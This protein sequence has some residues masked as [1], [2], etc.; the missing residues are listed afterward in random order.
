MRAYRR[1]SALRTARSYLAGPLFTPR[2]SQCILYSHLGLAR[3]ARAAAMASHTAC[4][5][6]R[7]AYEYM[8]AVGWSDGLPLVPPTRA[9]V[10]HML[11]GTARNP[12]QILG[13]CAPMYGEVTVEKVAI[14]SV[15][16]GRGGGCRTSA[17]RARA[18]GEGGGGAPSAAGFH[19]A[20][21]PQPLRRAERGG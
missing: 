3:R 17:W 8:S 1:V 5:F 2:I 11:T 7:D 18:R 14:N 6:G 16:A 4:L 15:M 10:A 20:P 9:R 13:H 19:D 12:H 21:R